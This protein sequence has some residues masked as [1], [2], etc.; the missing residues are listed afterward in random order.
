MASSGVLNQSFD[1]G[2]YIL[3]IEWR[4]SARDSTNYTS[5]IEWEAYFT[6]NTSY[7]VTIK[8][9]DISCRQFGKT[10]FE[11]LNSSMSRTFPANARTAIVRNG[12]WDTTIYAVTIAHDADGTSN[13]SIEYI[14]YDSTH[15]KAFSINDSITL[16]PIDKRISASFSTDNINVGET[17][18]ITTDNKLKCS[19]ELVASINGLTEKIAQ[20]EGGGTISWVI[21]DSFRSV[22]SSVTR[23]GIC[24]I[25]CKTY[26]IINHTN[27]EYE[28]D[29]TPIITTTKEY[30]YIGSKTYMLTLRVS[31]SDEPDIEITIEAF[32]RITNENLSGIYL[33]GYTYLEITNKCTAKNG[34]A[35]QSI[36]TTI[37]G[38]SYTG[39]TVITNAIP[40]TANGTIPI[41]VKATDSNG[42]SATFIKYIDITAYKPPKIGNFAIHRCLS[43]GRLD[44]EGDCCL[45]EYS[46]SV[47]PL[48]EYK[49]NRNS[50]LRASI[51][52]QQVKSDDFEED[53]PADSYDINC[54]SLLSHKGSMLIENVDTEA[55]FKITL[56]VEDKVTIVPV[57][58]TLSTAL[59]IVDIFRDGTGVAFGKVAEYPN[60][61]EFNIPV[62]FNKNFMPTEQ[63]INENTIASVGAYLGYEGFEDILGLQVDFE[64][65]KFTRLAASSGRNA[66]ADFD[67]FAMYGGR[68]RCNVADDGTINAFYGDTNYADD[69]TNGQVM[70][71]QPKFYYKVVP[72][73][74]EKNADTGIGYHIRKANYYVSD[75]QKPGFK[76]HPAFYDEHG[77]EVDYILYS[78]YEGVFKR[79]ADTI[80]Y[81]DATFTGSNFNLETDLIYSIAQRKPISGQNLALNITNAE[82]LCSNRGQ[83]WH[84]ETIKALS[85]NQLLM[86]IEYGTMDM[87][88][89]IGQG[90]CRLSDVTGKNCACNTG[91]TRT[92]GNA[93]GNATLTY[94]ITDGV[95][96]TYR[97]N[98]C[99][100]VTYRGVENP[101]GNIAQ[102]ISGIN[103]QSNGNGINRV[104]IADDFN[105][106][107]NKTDSNYHSPELT[108]ANDYGYINAFGYDEK[109]DWLFMPSEI[110]GTSILPVG[111]RLA[112]VPGSTVN[113]IVLNGGI[114]NQAT[115]CGA[116]QIDLQTN[117]NQAMRMNGCRLVYIPAAD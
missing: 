50:L 11:V 62:Q 28:E 18:K 55:C 117:Y 98:G 84:N 12:L 2:K 27:V 45:V 7:D 25:E 93:T 68:K 76:L 30:T 4:V 16:E 82:K 97:E 78:A 77:S 69:G 70:V 95:E 60:L 96:N 65:K 37:Y 39:N 75:T 47:D 72:L 9:G 58:D 112:V 6:N 115:Y 88:T 10:S 19:Y 90:I 89:A 61:I 102:M 113:K 79:A 57:S 56:A 74:L 109:Y 92:L 59:T 26:A 41:S 5:T 104:Y 80:F 38:Q 52:I 99:L 33:A 106:A 100:A 91:A 34:A 49:A 17:L 21:P 94:N 103:Y 73:K 107:V 85:A 83:G 8:K 43:D 13:P 63:W 40:R 14:I 23:T 42:L 67:G 111:D 66:G 24:T 44:D 86:M 114:W 22:I 35:I 32:S 116:F 1:D 15:G 48:V 53:Y 3:E 81:S 71:Y 110:G 36:I 20:G 31:E 105:F 101:Y 87:Q 108:I 54:A 46:F 29:G 64:N 51:V